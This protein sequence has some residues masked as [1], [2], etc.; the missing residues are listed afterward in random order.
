MAAWPLC[1]ASMLKYLAGRSGHLEHLADTS[2]K[3]LAV[4]SPHHRSGDSWRFGS[5]FLAVVAL[6][7]FLTACGDGGPMPKYTSNAPSTDPDASAAVDAGDVCPAFDAKFRDA[8]KTCESDG[9]CQAVLVAVSCNGSKKVFGVAVDQR[10]DFDRCLPMPS[11]SRACPSQVS[12]TRAEDGRVPVKADASD[13]VAHC[14]ARTCQARIDDRPCGDTTCHAGEL[15]V[16]RQMSG[17]IETECL[18]NPCG[19]KALDCTCAESVCQ[20]HSDKL[21]M[22][23]VE[24]VEDSDVFCKTVLR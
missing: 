5:A 7:T 3:C 11:A 10:E 20:V 1:R 4:K 18:P 15:C 9:D 24:Q 6:L 2:H 23:A 12:P 13:V 14:I 8:H 21:R 17:A 19:E 22:C 16:A